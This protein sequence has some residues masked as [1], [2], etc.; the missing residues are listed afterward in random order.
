MSCVY[1][2]AYHTGSYQVRHPHT[3]TY[4]ETPSRRHL[5][6]SLQVMRR[7]PEGMQHDVGDVVAMWLPCTPLASSQSVMW[8]ELTVLVLLCV[9]FPIV[10]WRKRLAKA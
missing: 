6:V 1:T 10:V 9:S 4:K 8:F 5:T 3:R 7:P 2:A